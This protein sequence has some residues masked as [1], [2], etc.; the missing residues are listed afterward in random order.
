M[1][2]FLFLLSLSLFLLFLCAHRLRHIPSLPSSVTCIA[3]TVKIYS[4]WSHH[5]RCHSSVSPLSSHERCHC[6]CERRLGFLLC[7]PF[8]AFFALTL[9]SPSPLFVDR[10]RSPLSEKTSS[11]RKS[12]TPFVLVRFLQDA[13]SVEIIATNLFL[14]SFM[15]TVPHEP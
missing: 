8:S 11:R 5:E 4:A 1:L 3:A 2:Q 15:L 13:S 12:A 14:S 10:H 7:L 6:Y 9:C